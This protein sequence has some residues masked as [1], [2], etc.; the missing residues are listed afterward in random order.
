MGDLA[1]RVN[2]GVGAAGGF[3]GEPGDFGQAKERLVDPIPDGIDRR[4][5]LP[6]APGRTAVGEIEPEFTRMGKGR[7]HTGEKRIM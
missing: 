3:H 1:Q 7:I 2:T 6:T 5:A 4:L